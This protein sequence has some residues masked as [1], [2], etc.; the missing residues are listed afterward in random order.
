MG[1]VFNNSLHFPDL[2]VWFS[3]IFCIFRIYGYGFQKILQIYGYTFEKFLQ[4]CG[5]YFCDLNGTT[6]YL[7]NSSYPPGIAP[8]M[9]KLVTFQRKGSSVVLKLL[10]NLLTG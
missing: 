8:V 6:P 9:S 5:W 4:I 2:W 10:L 7:G 3:T 1:I